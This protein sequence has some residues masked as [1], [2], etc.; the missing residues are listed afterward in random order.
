MC[1]LTLGF[2]VLVRQPLPYGP[3]RRHARGPPRHWL[4]HMR[5]PCYDYCDRGMVFLFFKHTLTHKHSAARRRRY[6][7]PSP[8]QPRAEVDA[9]ASQHCALS[10]FVTAPSTNTSRRSAHMH[11]CI[12]C[13]STLTQSSQQY[14]ALS[15]L[16]V[17]TLRMTSY[18]V[19]NLI[20]AFVLLWR[21]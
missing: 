16:V 10:D 19:L 4:H 17:Q 8:A 15:L 1:H 14:T 6:C 2:Q 18:P 13:H 12:S 21:A 9:V 7:A 11:R 5:W 3:T 20:N